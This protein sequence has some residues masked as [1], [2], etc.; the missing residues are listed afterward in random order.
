[1][2][3]SPVISSITASAKL[4]SSVAESAISSFLMISETIPRTRRRMVSS[5]SLSRTDK[6]SS[7]I[8]LAWIRNLASSWSKALVSA[9]AGGAGFGAV[10]SATSGALTG[11]GLAAAFENPKRLISLSSYRQ[12]VERAASRRRAS[13]CRPMSRHLRR[14]RFSVSRHQSAFR[15][16]PPCGQH[17]SPT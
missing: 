5:S 3:P 6:S 15:D 11:S 14:A 17:P 9:G 13:S 7:S 10:G 8:S 1:M 4:A 2:G 12:L 16:L